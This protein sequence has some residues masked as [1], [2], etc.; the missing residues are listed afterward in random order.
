MMVT[1]LTVDSP[2]V[3]VCTICCS[4]KELRI[5]SHWSSTVHMLLTVNTEHF[6]EKHELCGFYSEGRVFFCVSEVET[7]LF[8][9]FR[10]SSFFKDTWLEFIK[11]VILRLI[12]MFSTLT[13][14]YLR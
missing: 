13:A 7:V 3:T 9:Q 6:P 1:V 12:F 14:S 8:N 2:L 4:I 10:C 5:L 11:Q